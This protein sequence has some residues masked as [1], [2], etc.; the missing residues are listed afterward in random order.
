MNVSPQAF[1]L[2]TR[3]YIEKAQ[4]AA[5]MQE[6]KAL[7]PAAHLLH[8][9]EVLRVRDPC[10]ERASRL[11]SKPSIEGSLVIEMIGH[12]QH[13]DRPAEHV[14]RVDGILGRCGTSHPLQSKA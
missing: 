13:G 7:D 9:A 3:R 5:P 6:A 10:L 1:A 11:V 2:M 12:A 14:D 4:L 8:R